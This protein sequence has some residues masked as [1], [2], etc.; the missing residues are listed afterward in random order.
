MLT[1]RRPCPSPFF[2]SAVVA[3]LFLGAPAAHAETRGKLT[4]TITDARTREPL[5]GVNIVLAG[6]AMGAATDPDGVF[7]ILNVPAGTYEVRISSIGYSTRVVR[8]VRINAGQTT[9]LNEALTEEVVQGQEVI[10]VATRPVVDTR[11]TSAVSILDRKDISA[12]PV[13]ELNDIVNLQAGVVDGHFRGGRVGEVQY[14]VDGVSINNPY[15]NSA[16]I[17]I[18]KSILQEVQVVSGTFDAEYGQA[19]SGVVNA[20]LRSGS[21]DRFEYSV[22]MFGG[23][24]TG[25]VSRFP[26][27]DRI[28]PAAIQ[29]YQFSLSGPTPLPSTTFLLS[30]RRYTDDGY[31]YGQRRF[32]PF[33]TSRPGEG[34]F[35]PT[36]DNA[37]VP[38]SFFREWSGQAKIATRISGDMQLSYQAV[39]NRSERGSYSYGWRLNPDG[40]KQPRSL[41]LVHGLDWT[42]TLSQ[43]MFYTFSLR[44]N[45]FDYKDVKYDDINDPRYYTAKGPVSDANYEYG[46]V[47]QGVDL[48]RFMQRTDSYVAKG[49]LTWQATRIHLLKA[50]FEAQGAAI[51]FGPPGIL[52]AST[53]AQGVQVIT[54]FVNHPEQPRI[55]SN[56]P[57]W[58]SSFVQDKMEF[59][60]LLVRAGARLELFHAR[61]TIP[62]DLANPANAIPGAP[63]K[64]PVGTTIKAS[65]A[66]RLGISYPI[67]D[68]ASV[69]F[70]YGHFYQYPALSNLFANNDYSV[71]RN[72]QAGGISYG[73]MGNPDLRPERTTQYE[74]GY[75]GA[76]TEAFGLDVS[77]Y[78]KDIRD[79][80]GVEFV[81]TYTAAEYA[82]FTNVDFGNVAGAT[83]ALDYR[84]GILSASLD[85]TFQTALGN[86]SDPRETATRAA[87]GEDPR[88]RVVPLGWDQRHTL[89]A[90]L[91]LSE[92]GSYSA[93]VIARFQSGQPYTPV[94]TAGFGGDIETN[95]GKKSAS[96]IV[97]MRT[98]KQLDLFGV[99]LTVFS[100]IQNL[101]GAT[102]S[103]GFIFAST[104]S[105]DYSLVP[106]VDRNTLADPSRFYAPRRIEIGLSFGGS[107]E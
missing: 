33:D 71:L 43:T 19:M 56:H 65:L 55:V 82:R 72:L 64:V 105:P 4:G 57:L 47:I 54:P 91:G 97:D 77:V 53:N 44:Q 104:G 49:S 67:T 16:S 103:N 29:S 30:V 93:T 40:L 69:F 92:A 48:G 74:F 58:F 11:Q 7:L 28:S 84:A 50:G 95:S 85:Y 13:Q 24:Y 75:K 61:T 94:L 106:A 6:T 9:T 22:E 52:I 79:L 51:Q 12:L 60:D 99:R 17:R 21:T 101:F 27:I 38:M 88:P 25:S 89:N 68:L 37:L 90:V 34:A 42:H 26:H 73:V 70:S 63:V 100:R 76:L 46:A 78:Y 15:D 14:Q 59:T 66:P 107:S 5:I 2:L 18:D 45:Y 83:L 32:S 3:V 81:S 31:L 10:V 87:A 20:V 35:Y 86:S 80:L 98:E 23:D 8:D 41:A 96:V 62:G 102:F 1:A 39:F 36:G